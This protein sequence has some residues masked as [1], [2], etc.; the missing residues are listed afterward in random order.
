MKNSN[1][2]NQLQ[3]ISDNQ[4]IRSAK[5]L[6]HNVWDEL[7]QDSNSSQDRTSHYRFLRPVFGE[8]WQSQEGNSGHWANI[9]SVE[10]A[11]Q[12][13]RLTI[14]AHN[15][16][17]RLLPSQDRFGV[18]NNPLENSNENA[19]E[20]LERYSRVQ[21]GTRDL[22]GDVARN[23]FNLGQLPEHFR[24]GMSGNVM[25]ADLRGFIRDVKS[26]DQAQPTQRSVGGSGGVGFSASDT[27]SQENPPRESRPVNIAK[28][29][30]NANYLKQLYAK[31]PS[32]TESQDQ[33]NHLIAL[34]ASTQDSEFIVQ[35]E[36]FLQERGIELPITDNRVFHQQKVKPERRN[37]E[38]LDGEQLSARQEE[39]IGTKKKKNKATYSQVISKQFNIAINPQE[40]SLSL[41][42]GHCLGLLQN[43]IN[44]FRD[45]APDP[46]ERKYFE[47]RDLGKDNLSKL[48]SSRDVND[49]RKNLQNIIKKDPSHQKAFRGLFVDLIKEAY[50]REF[51]HAKEI[52]CRQS[53]K[54][55]QEAQLESRELASLV[56]NMQITSKEGQEAKREYV[57]NQFSANRE[58][59]LLYDVR[60]FFVRKERMAQGNISTG[61]YDLSPHHQIGA[62]LDHLKD[63][64]NG[65][66]NKY[67][68]DRHI[69]IYNFLADLGV[70]DNTDAL[71]R[72]GEDL[73]NCKVRKIEDLTLSPYQQSCLLV[74]S[75]L[76]MRVGGVEA[77]LLDKYALM[78]AN[79][80]NMDELT[81]LIV[82]NQ[83]R[84]FPVFGQ[85]AKK[86]GAGNLFFNIHS[87]LNRNNNRVDREELDSEAVSEAEGVVNRI[88][89][90][91]TLQEKIGGIES[92]V[93]TSRGRKKRIN[94]APKV[95][96]LLQ[97]E[98]N[99]MALLPGNNPEAQTLVDG[100]AERFD[101]Y[102]IK[103][104]EYGRSNQVRTTVQ[105]ARE[106]IS[107]LQNTINRCYNAFIVLGASNGDE[108]MVKKALEKGADINCSEYNS[109]NATPLIVAAENGHKNIVN[110]LLDNGADFE[111]V[112]VHGREAVASALLKGHLEIA[113]WLLEL[114]NLKDGADV[115][116]SIDSVIVTYKTMQKMIQN[117]G[118]EGRTFSNN[119]MRGFIDE[120]RR[121]EKDSLDEVLNMFFAGEKEID[122]QKGIDRIL[123]SGIV[124]E[125]FL[126]DTLKSGI[127]D[128]M[129]GLVSAMG[130]TPDECLRRIGDVVNSRSQQPPA[131]I[132]P[133]EFKGMDS[134]AKD[135]QL[136]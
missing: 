96:E 134:K 131:S 48:K 50:E 17:L 2:S 133:Q 49:F 34:Y 63:N 64:G 68:K 127:P 84:E 58:G 132:S 80:N 54:L 12:A 66:N 29:I 36:Q 113:Q 42:D 26:F 117:G 76:D 121:E 1:N 30:H 45:G 10:K 74:L 19:L 125:D 115:D 15:N 14:A 67:E 81:V 104:Q 136:G 69:K 86:E 11:T 130:T 93:T 75:A 70:V 41:F 91:K 79:A 101:E 37:A 39:K 28:K 7:W 35:T 31:L 33:V 83:G 128:D 108:N 5:D 23:I 46:E 97:K 82:S 44:S 24:V 118:L 87:Q 18:N 114:K 77:N 124:S 25:S 43:K 52:E 98:I 3:S 22:A 116:A 122:S 89:I 129:L 78:M 94:I 32:D 105:M 56:A 95:V 4:L 90:G 120:I 27:L 103:Y 119:D 126:K 73:I 53:N 40:G 20:I 110:L 9:D 72:D 88:K 107:D 21:S 99:E 71:G 85:E 135:P 62:V 38:S 60:E 8:I 123:G 57:R 59:L 111:A 61:Y 47:E 55:Q 92:V 6:M 109:T 16:L 65:T 51:Y 112:D 102:I 13:V 100:M 106:D